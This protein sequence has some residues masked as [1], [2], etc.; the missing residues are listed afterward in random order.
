MSTKT[1]YIQRNSRFNFTRSE[2]APDALPKNQSLPQKHGL[3]LYPERISG[4]SFTEKRAKNKQTFL[5]RILPSTAQSAWEEL[6]K[7]PIN[8]DFQNRLRFIPDQLVWPPQ[9]VQENVSF[10]DGLNIIG[11]AGDPVMKNG[12]AYYF[13][14]CGKS[15]S[16]SEAF[17]NADGDWLIGTS[18]ALSRLW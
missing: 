18:A 3:G 9:E 2:A 16:E 8:A 10:L 15:M 13:Y 6:A 1:S 5:Y 4:T 11:G 12:V 7:H 14:S 17:Y